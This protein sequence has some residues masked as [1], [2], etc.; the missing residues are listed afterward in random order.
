MVAD[1]EAERPQEVRDLVRPRLQLPVGEDVGGRRRRSRLGGRVRTPRTV[2]GARCPRRGTLASETSR[3][4]QPR[5]LGWTSRRPTDPG[6]A[7]V[8][9]DDPR[10]AP[11]IGPGRAVRGRGRGGRRHRAAGL[12]PR[13][14]HDRRRVRDGR[15]PRRPRPRRLRGRA[16]DARASCVDRRAASRASCRRRSACGRGPRRDR[17]AEPPEYVVAF[18]GIALNGAVVVPLNAW[19]TS[20]E[21]DYALRD[22]GV[23]VLFADEDRVARVLARTAG[24]TGLQI[25]RR[26]HRPRRRRDRRPHQRAS[27]SP[28]TRSRAS[29]A[30]TRSSSCTRR[31]PPAGPRAR[32]S[33][34]ER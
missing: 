6:L 33:R 27:R 26:A 8:Y 20:D 10:L 28:T 5:I 1:A 29:T 17:D 30:T 11:L 24:P 34:T 25:D 7:P 3:F 12:R 31:A 18:W 15:R 16:V 4:L 14:A 32:S 23:T 2:S 19:W 21:L 22:A 13:A 9:R